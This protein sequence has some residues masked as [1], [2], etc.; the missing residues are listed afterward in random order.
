MILCDYEFVEACCAWD[1][2]VTRGRM[3]TEYM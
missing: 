1:A 3:I 2:G